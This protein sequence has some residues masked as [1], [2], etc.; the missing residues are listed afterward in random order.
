MI[1]LQ[2]SVGLIRGVVSL[3]Y[4]NKDAIV[5]DDHPYTILKDIAKRRLE[6]E[7]VGAYAQLSADVTEARVLRLRGNA[8]DYRANQWRQAN[9]MQLR[10][11]EKF[12]NFSQEEIQGILVEFKKLQDRKRAAKTNSLSQALP[13]LDGRN[14]LVTAHRR[15]TVNLAPEM[16]N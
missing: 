6:S 15:T 8:R 16:M 10:K 7:L 13:K 14:R 11:L 5:N 12:S 9:T 4:I 3:I 2:G 1:A